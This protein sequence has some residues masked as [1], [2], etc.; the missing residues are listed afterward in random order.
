MASSLTAKLWLPNN[1]NFG[2]VLKEERKIE[3]SLQ[4]E[5]KQQSEF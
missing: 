3:G 2:E 5:E 1:Y 4:G